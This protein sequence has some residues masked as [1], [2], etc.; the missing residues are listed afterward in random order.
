MPKRL[1]SCRNPVSP[2]CWSPFSEAFRSKRMC[3]GRRRRVCCWLPSRVRALG[4]GER[5]LGLWRSPTA[6]GLQ[7]WGLCP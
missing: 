2:L 1:L 7:G 6:W 3:S 4:V 5:S